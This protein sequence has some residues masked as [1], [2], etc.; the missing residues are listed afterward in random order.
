MV[1]RNLLWLKQPYKDMNYKTLFP[2]FQ[3]AAIILA[4][5]VLFAS[6]TD[7][8]TIWNGPT[9]AF[10]DLAGTDPTQPENQDRITPNVWITRGSLQGIYNIKTETSFT[11]FF[12]PAGTEWANGT[13]ANY[14][15]LSYTNWNTWAKNV[16]PGPPSTVGVNAVV[17]LISDDIYIDVKFTSWPVGAGFSYIRSTPNVTPPPPAQPALNGSA[18]PGNG[19]FQLTFTNT[20]DYTFT[21]LGTTNLSLSLT[22]WP[23]L[24]QVTDAPPGSGLYQFT[25]SGAG[26]N[27]TQRFYR[28]R[29][30]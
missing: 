15:S 12:S 29:W 10:T 13:T 21:V 16:N 25:D 14:A 6:Q 26:T 7:G 17:H 11:H 23:V 5:I 22:D 9:I 20:P 24:G 28:V 1:F 8:D 4:A 3:P 27:Q 18:L 19:S 2:R 30:P